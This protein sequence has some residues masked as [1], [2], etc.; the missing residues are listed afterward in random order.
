MTKTF[1]IW[2][3]V[4]NSRVSIPLSFFTLIVLFGCYFGCITGVA[5]RV[6]ESPN[7]ELI[8]HF[9][10]ACM[11][12]SNEPG[13]MSLTSTGSVVVAFSQLEIGNILG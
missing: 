7:T 4:Y 10:S 6:N 13:V 3:R 2:V 12:V 9:L 5:F 8:K 11:Y 1:T